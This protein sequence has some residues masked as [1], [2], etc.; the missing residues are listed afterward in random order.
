MK[1]K[2]TLKEV[3]NNYLT[4]TSQEKGITLVALIITIVILIILATV[5]INVVFGEG[6][7]IEQS[8][9][10]AEKTA[11]SI[12]DEE[13]NLTNLLG[14]FNENMKEEV[15]SLEISE[16]KSIEITTS[17]ITVA[18]IV[19]ENT[20]ETLVYEYKIE[21]GEYVEG[22]STYKFSDLQAG[23]E[24]TF[25]V[26][27]TDEKGNKA[28]QTLTQTT[29]EMP[30]KETINANIA[31]W[32]NG[33]ATVTVSTTETGYTLEYQKNDGSWE[34]VPE[35]GTITGLVHGDVINVRLTN[36]ISTSDVL[37]F[38]VQDTTPPIITSFKSTS[39]T[40]SS[41]TVTTKATDNTGGTLK[42]EYRKGSGSYVT[43][44]S[45]YSFTGLSSDTTYTLEVRVTD[46]AGLTTT[47]SIQASTD[48][49]MKPIPGIPIG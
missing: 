40:T 1:T 44:K 6:G 11:N 14:Y 32:S 17:S 18:T 19:A 47:K 24:Y 28:I 37:T 20:D 31:G 45:T 48:R 36:G 7:I 39:T 5:T 26:R 46:E 27:V 3:A 29:Q 33:Q 16:F 10:V 9:L 41:I 25:T 30:D 43:G 49:P 8:K 23:K 4:Q 42:Y 12:Y 21:N 34:E 13:K 2:S 35:S 22:S 38:N 15:D